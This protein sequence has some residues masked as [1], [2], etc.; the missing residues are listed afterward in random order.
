MVAVQ[1]WPRMEGENRPARRRNRLPSII[2]VSERQLRLSFELAAA[3]LPVD[4]NYPPILVEGRRSIRAD[5]VMPAMR[6]VVE[7][8][9]SYYHARKA[10][11][12]RKQTTDLESVEWT[13]VRVREEP[14]PALGGHEI[15]VG[16][17]EPIKSVTI[18]VLDSLAAIGIHALHK[19]EYI[20]DPNEWGKSQANEAL[21][22]YR[23]KN[24]A[25][26]F[27]SVAKEFDPAKNDGIAP[28]EVHP[29]SQ[30]KFL[31]T[32]PECSLTN[33]IHPCG[34]AQPATDVLAVPT[35][36]ER[37]SGGRYPCQGNRLPTCFLMWQKKN[38]IRP[39]TGRSQRARYA[40]VAGSWS[41]G[42]ALAGMTGRLGSSTA[43]RA[44]GV[45]SA[46][47]SSVPKEG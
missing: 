7:Y 31:W 45:E 47:R 43:E 35:N 46:E 22:K 41:G 32:C 15:F 36:V 18:K 19:A 5:I 40:Q 39:S 6:L 13:V 10:R 20:G 3:G 25:S 29:G 12:D 16:P 4:H 30:T 21:Y 28:E 9:G 14:L 23:A 33:G 42:N 34:S 8:D 44:C 2:G 11:A 1:V 24:L 26:E 27:P 17:I 38:G 37:R